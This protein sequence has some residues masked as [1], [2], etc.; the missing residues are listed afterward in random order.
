MTLAR[1]VKI[2]PAFYKPEILYRVKN[3]LPTF[4]TLKHMNPGNHIFYLLKVYFSVTIL[5]ISLS[6]SVSRQHFIRIS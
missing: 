3:M 1:L 5:S 6:L 4:P 2:I